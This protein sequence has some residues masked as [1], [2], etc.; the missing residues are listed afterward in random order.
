MSAARPPGWR[1]RLDAH[2]AQAAVRPFAWGE[3]DCALF[4]AGA[5]AAIT[6]EDPAAP[7][8]GRYGSLR[9]GLQLLAAEAGVADHAALAARLLTEV[10][11]EEAQ[12]GDVAVLDDGEPGGPGGL[13]LLG[14]VVG[15]RVAV[16]RA[17]GLAT[18]P[19]LVEEDGSARLAIQRAFRP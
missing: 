12:I 11:P 6:G 18:V 5:V 8:R 2:L 1:G 7:W 4:A 9:Q 3:Q 14:V 19:L 15:S 16:L 17:D 13:P 10:P